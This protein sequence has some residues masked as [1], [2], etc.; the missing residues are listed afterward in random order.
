MGQMQA[1]VVHRLHGRDCVDE[2]IRELLEGKR[3]L[4]DLYAKGSAVKDASHQATET[5]MAKAVVAVEQARL[6]ETATA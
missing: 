4:F 6:L 2:R 3:E 1:V 5:E